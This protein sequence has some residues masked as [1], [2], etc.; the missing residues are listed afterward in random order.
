MSG[1]ETSCTNLRRVLVTGATGFVGRHLVRRLAADG[2]AVHVLV[3]PQ[4]NLTP[5]QGFS[6]LSIHIDD[7]E[8]S[9]HEMLDKAAPEVVIH[10]A[11]HFVA[12]HGPGDLGPM[13]EANILFGALMLESMA[14]AGTA[15]LVNAGT[16]CQVF[17]DRE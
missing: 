14:R 8:G 17:E 12:E 6:G 15:R 16:S 5:L 2:V 7:G 13:V 1:E 4:S 9:L 11:A 10:L 3:R